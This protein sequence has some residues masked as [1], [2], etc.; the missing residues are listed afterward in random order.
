MSEAIIK[1]EEL[2]KVYEIGIRTEALRGISLDIERGSFTCIMGPSGHGKST[3]LH[4]IG[5]LDRPTCGRVYIEGL[6][7]TRISDDELAEI[8]LKKMGFVFQFFNLAPNL[9]AIENVELPLMFTGISAGKQKERARELLKL[10]GLED[11]ILAKPSQLSGGQQQRVAIA[12]ALANNPDI[13]LMDEPTGNLDSRS[14]AE[15]LEYINRAHKERKT[16]VLATHNEGIAQRA[17]TVIRLSD[18]RVQ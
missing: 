18:G 12:R 7:V 10:L 5:G 2:T 4:I 14:E 1:T 6:D 16:I 3:L 13:L 17:Q 9:T 11:K 15:V 8:R